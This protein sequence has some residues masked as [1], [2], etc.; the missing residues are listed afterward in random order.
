MLRREVGIAVFRE[1]YPIIDIVNR[2]CHRRR[3]LT[4]DESVIS[5]VIGID[6]VMYGIDVDRLK[7]RELAAAIFVVNFIVK[8]RPSEEL[9]QMAKKRKD[10][11]HLALA[12]RYNGY[13]V[14]R[15]GYQGFVLVV[16]Q[17]DYQTHML[18]RYLPRRR[19]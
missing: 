6:I 5:I 12:E 14:H 17:G 15:S 9:H 2:K 1:A 3:N 4:F 19:R 10:L 16:V 11:L 18:R 7:T 8:M 13:K